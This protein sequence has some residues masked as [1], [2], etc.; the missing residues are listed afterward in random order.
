MPN[1]TMLER[2]VA[3]AILSF[4]LA[5]HPQDPDADIKLRVHL[6]RGPML[7]KEFNGYLMA[8]MPSLDIGSKDRLN[9]WKSFS[10]NKLKHIIKALHDDYA[11]SSAE[12][13]AIKKCADCWFPELSV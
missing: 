11:P 4:C 10:L 9:A 1:T 7:S 8:L 5:T 13:D 2:T 6:Q 3:S 12:R